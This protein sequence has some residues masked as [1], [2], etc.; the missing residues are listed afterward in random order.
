MHPSSYK[1]DE[2]KKIVRN[3]NRLAKVLIEFELMFHE[4]W[5]KSVDTCTNSRLL[6][7]LLYS[8]SISYERVFLAV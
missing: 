2:A 3:Y 6:K 8:I 7:T 1:G 5:K 4:A